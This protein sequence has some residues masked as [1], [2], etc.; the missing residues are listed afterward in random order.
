MSTLSSDLRTLSYEAYIYFYPLVTMDI[1]RLQT[2][3]RTG[4]GAGPPN[5]FHHIREYPDADFRA[6]VRPNFDTLYSSAWLDLTQGPVILDVPDTDDRYF[7]LPLLDMW[8]DVF[9]N[10]GKR[11]SGTGPQRYVIVGPGDTGE[12]PQDIPVIH[13]PTPHVW[14]I[15]RTQTNGPADYAAVHAVQDGYTLTPLAASTFVRD[16]TYDVA[17]E[18]LRKVNAMAALDY[19]TYAADLL[20]VNPPHPT[21]FSI[22]ARLS[23]LGIEA[24]KSF[25]AQRF[26]AEQR[27]E[28]EAGAQDALAAITSSAP[29]LGTIVDGWMTLSEGMGVYGNAYLRR[30]VVTLVGLGANPP[31]DAVYPMLV[32]DADGQ[33]L[34]GEN[35]Y[36]IHFD[37]GK[38]PPVDAFWSVTM[39]DAE[40]YQ[41]ANEIDRFAIGDRDAL[42][43]NADGSLDLYLQHSNPGPEKL[44]NW[45]PAP[46]G[47]LGVT[48]RLYAPRREAIAGTWHPPVVRKV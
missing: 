28:I 48:M 22:L 25:G 11:T 45:L 6:V 24:G 33:P 34:A 39:Y 37:A 46:L 36:V 23:G 17:T 19:L 31:E 2:L 4:V 30:A 7:M 5:E 12:L 3:N 27:A 13:A 44:S 14:I 32:T 20:S 43:Y 47:T 1:S 40:G 8:T 9:A 21:D 42:Q 41:V 38:L 10:P 15:G 16:E 35:D 29:T 18:P 26:S